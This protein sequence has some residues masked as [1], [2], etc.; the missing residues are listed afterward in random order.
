M[1]TI[2]LMVA[3]G[4]LFALGVLYQKWRHNQDVKDRSCPCKDH[5]PKKPCVLCEKKPSVKYSLCVDCLGRHL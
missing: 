4:A 3:L 5:T 1:K 2:L